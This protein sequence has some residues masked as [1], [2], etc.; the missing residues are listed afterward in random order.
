MDCTR[1]LHEHAVAGLDDA[2][3]LADRLLG[4][5]GETLDGGTVAGEVAA[6]RKAADG[7]HGVDTE[8]RRVRTDLLVVE[9]AVEPELEHLAEHG[10]APACA[11]TG[12]LVFQRSAHRDGVRVVGGVDEQAAAGER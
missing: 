3:D 10:D 1:S 12:G 11:R 8:L 2:P 7:E 9:E 4:A 5:A 6:G